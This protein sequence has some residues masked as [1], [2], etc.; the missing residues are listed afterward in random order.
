MNIQDADNMNIKMVKA[1]NSVFLNKLKMFS[2]SNE[3]YRSIFGSINPQTD[4]DILNDD[5]FKDIKI[6]SHEI[7][8]KNNKIVRYINIV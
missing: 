8:K 7:N 3:Q 5:Q 2:K 4:I 1:S 6:L